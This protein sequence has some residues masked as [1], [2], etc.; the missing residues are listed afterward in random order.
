MIRRGRFMGTGWELPR[1]LFLLVTSSVGWLVIGI[2]LVVGGLI[3]GLNSR[4][5]SYQTYSISSNYQ[6][7]TGKASGNVYLNADGS[8]DFFAAFTYDFSP[9]INPDD[10]DKTAAVSFIARTDTSALNPALTANGTTITSA[11]KIEQL[12]LYDQRGNIIRTYNSTEYLANPNG[13]N[14]NYWPYAG[15]LML[16]GV[17]C[18]G[19][20][21]LFLTRKKQRQKVAIQAEL[22]RLEATP[23][24]FAR[25]LGQMASTQ[26]YQGFEQYPPVNPQPYRPYQTPQE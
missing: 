5:A 25:E 15:I 19:N 3:W 12:V 6:I 21:L 2:G 23:S 22:A 20:A 11:H 1:L 8:N 13:Y 9:T 14:A 4:Q 10:L 7:G 26:A 16:A 17:L 18:S 24:P